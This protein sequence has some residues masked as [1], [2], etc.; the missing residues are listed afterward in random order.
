MTRE[1]KPKAFGKRTV[2]I[3]RRGKGRNILY[4]ALSRPEVRNCL[5]D[6][7]YDDLTEV[8]RMAARD[9]SIS[10]VVLTG[11]GEYFSSGADLKSGSFTPEKG[12]RH[13]LFKPVGRFMMELVSFPK[14]LAAAVNGPVSGWM[15]EA[16]LSY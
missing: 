2:Q 3:C 4:V 14:I 12:G 11:C 1:E 10:A 7:S 9:P 5:S 6:E 8:L 16:R 15:N 13:T